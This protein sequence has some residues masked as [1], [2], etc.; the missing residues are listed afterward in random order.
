MEK[1]I[2]IKIPT[3]EQ[4]M[5]FSAWDETIGVFVAICVAVFIGLY[6]G[7]TLFMSGFLGSKQDN[8]AW[9]FL[10]FLIGLGLS[11]ATLSTTG[12]WF[13]GCGV[14]VM[15]LITLRTIRERAGG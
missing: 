15:S 1:T 3:L 5:N 6:L 2:T 10:N 13:A 11:L 9:V 14:A 7:V 4:L 12:S 8:M